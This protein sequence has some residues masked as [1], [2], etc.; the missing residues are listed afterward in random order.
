MGAILDESG[1]TV[2]PIHLQASSIP[3]EVTQ[4][5]I[6]RSIFGTCTELRS[7]LGN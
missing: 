4:V 1:E 3:W 6:V 2:Q 5:H 7:E